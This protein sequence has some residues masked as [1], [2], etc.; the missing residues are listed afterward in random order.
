MDIRHLPGDPTLVRT[1]SGWHQAE[2]GHLSTRTTED[3]I[4]EFAEHG[5]A[6]PQ[7]Q[8]AFLDGRPAGTA[9]LLVH[10]MDILP[11]L[12]P[13]LASVYVLP[14]L[15]RRGIGTRLVK[16]IAAEAGRLAIPALYLF[17]EDRAGFYAAMGWETLEERAYHGEQVTI[18]K[19]ELG[20]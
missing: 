1:I 13:W 4:A 2:W 14:E 19:L 16:A 6:V 10:D 5:T 12:T 11:E 7:T 15:R 8:V 20:G 17:T 18:M 3:R 9:S